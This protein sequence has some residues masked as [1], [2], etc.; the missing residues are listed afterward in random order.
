MNYNNPLLETIEE[1]KEKELVMPKG[2]NMHPLVKL[3]D[4]IKALESL[5]VKIWTCCEAEMMNKHILNQ[6]NY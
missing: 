3:E 5:D 1:L 4:A 6:E 2:A